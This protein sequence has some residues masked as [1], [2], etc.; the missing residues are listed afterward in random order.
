MAVI[1]PEVL[2]FSR[3][4]NVRPW[5]HISKKSTLITCVAILIFSL[6][7]NS[8]RFFEYKTKVTLIHK[9]MEMFV[10]FE[11]KVHIS[12]P[13]NIE[14]LGAIKLSERD[15]ETM[16]TWKLVVPTDLRMNQIYLQVSLF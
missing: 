4:K 1:A 8:S 11:Q 5:K 16:W 14:I 7:I 15:A 2:V 9:R 3:N 13:G 12:M 6:F 10:M